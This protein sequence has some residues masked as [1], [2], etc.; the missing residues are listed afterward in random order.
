MLC[1]EYEPPFPPVYVIPKETLDANSPL[2]NEPFTETPAQFKEAIFPGQIPPV[3]H[4]GM[5]SQLVMI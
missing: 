3:V 1:D 2:F 5:P 4:V